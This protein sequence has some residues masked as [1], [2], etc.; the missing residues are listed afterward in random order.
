[1]SGGPHAT[2]ARMGKKPAGWP[3]RS[4]GWFGGV[5]TV[6]IAPQ[7]SVCEMRDTATR[8]MRRRFQYD[9]QLTQGPDLGL[10]ACLNVVQRGLARKHE[11]PQFLQQFLAD[12][13][14]LTGYGR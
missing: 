4:S 9:E 11:S 8:R 3:V 7:A 14:I 5:A 13:D 12:L 6:S 1:M 10:A 2:D